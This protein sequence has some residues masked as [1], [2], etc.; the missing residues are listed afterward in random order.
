MT[1]SYC[2]AVVHLPIPIDHNRDY[3]HHIQTPNS[4]HHAD[5]LSANLRAP[6]AVPTLAHPQYVRV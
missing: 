5:P 2:Y 4:T 3:G 1:A 6:A